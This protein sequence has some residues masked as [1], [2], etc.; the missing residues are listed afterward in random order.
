MNR[1]M[2]KLLTGLVAVS[3]TAA[4]PVA[5]MAAETGTL[6]EPAN[7]ADTTDKTEEQ[8]KENSNAGVTEGENEKNSSDK[9]AGDEKQKKS[10][11]KETG[12]E[13]NGSTGTNDQQGTGSETNGTNNQKNANDEKTGAGQSGSKTGNVQTGNSQN[14]NGQN[15]ND[16]KGQTGN[17]QTGNDLNTN[18]G[19][20]NNNG[21]GTPATGESANTGSSFGSSRTLGSNNNA[22][23]ASVAW[24]GETGY[25]TLEAA[26]NAAQSGD[27]I[28][29][30]EGTYTLYKKGAD[31]QNK[32][33]T[34]VGAGTDKT[35]WLIGPTVPDPAKYGT[36]Y[37]SDYSFDVEGTPYKETVTF[38]DMTLQTGKVDYL[39]FARADNTV[40]ENCV[41]EGKTFYWG[42]TSATF[43]NTTFNT[44]D[45]DYAIW[46]YC[47]PV[48][49]FDG[50][51]FNTTNGKTINVY[52]DYSRDKFD[53]VV[54]FKNITVNATGATKKT[55]LKINDKLET[56]GY[57]FYI[58][59][60]GD[61][62]INGDVK[63]DTSY[64]CSR[65]F[66]FDEDSEN[67]GHT[68]VT[69]DGTKVYEN[70]KRLGHE[71]DLENGHQYTE[72]YAD[73]AYD[74]TESEWTET[75]SGT[76]TRSV[77][78]KCRYCEEVLGPKTER[79]YELTYDA[80]GGDLVAVSRTRAASS[81]WEYPDTEIDI[82]YGAER[83]GYTF[84]GWNDKKDG[85]GT[86]YGDTITLKAPTTLYAQWKCTVS[87]NANEGTGTVASQSGKED[88]NVEVAAGSSLSR[89]GYRFAGWN[90]KSDGT[91]TSYKAGAS[92]KL[93]GNVTLYAQWDKEYTVSYNANGGTG[94][95]A[96]VTGIKGDAVQAA[97]G[98]AM[99]R[100]G[101][102]FAGWNSKA[103]GSGTSYAAGTQLT[104][105]DADVTLY[106]QWKVNAQASSNASSN[107]SSN[108]NSG[109]S[110]NSGTSGSSSSASSESSSAAQSTQAVLGAQR[111]TAAAANAA[112]ENAAVQTTV[113]NTADTEQ[114]AVL[115]ASREEQQTG[116][117]L[118]KTRGVGTGD[119]SHMAVWGGIFAAA[120]LGL[121]IVVFARKRRGN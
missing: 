33:L 69:I 32:D 111:F 11:D 53:I 44:P 104:L 20:N 112:A 79:Q 87:Y 12:D 17:D 82:A 34:F 110:Q 31:V 76:R 15:G 49:N 16:L 45:G 73:N 27:T 5:V 70:G 51:I 60:S 89:T 55:V 86:N 22:N 62:K 8:N 39:G 52:T 74:V 30:G 65:W 78:K 115:G 24:I 92:M 99:S 95:I 61:N 80:N 85:S 59:I 14:E 50:C 90:T 108:E 72:G 48:M 7:I 97:D 19:A 3:L 18:N 121:V 10:G 113:Q 56:Y 93:A 66:G 2:M 106:A 23:T 54:N 35:T 37:N 68:V 81:V 83:D 109:S 40:V 102:T 94:S 58:N 4:Q 46:T 47:S 71:F 120:A 36:E 88:N 41:I 64:T 103:D 38:K 1:Q 98:A 116:A 43:K 100:S 9:A 77:T 42:Y 6:T 119:E 28:T 84:D 75:S 105:A 29:L 63:R 117:V 118:G 114:G 101:Y 57:G 96:A 13:K 21:N 25:T 26:V 107:T 91:G 67:A